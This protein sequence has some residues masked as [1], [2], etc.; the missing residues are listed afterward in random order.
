MGI[1]IPTLSRG[2]GHCS[3]ERGMVNITITENSTRPCTWQRRVGNTTT[4]KLRICLMC[5]SESVSHRAGG[6]VS[7]SKSKKHWFDWNV[8]E[9]IEWF[10]TEEKDNSPLVLGEDKDALRNL[11]A[12]LQARLRI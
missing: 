5:F 10:E 3:S 9:W 12:M 11:I 1:R 4:E 6:V 8:D 2:S 7:M